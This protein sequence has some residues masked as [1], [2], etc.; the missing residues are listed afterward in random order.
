[1][2]PFWSAR[3]V[4]AIVSLLTAMSLP[5]L[6]ATASASPVNV[7]TRSGCTTYWMFNGVWRVRVTEA[8]AYID[9]ITH[10]QTGWQ[11]SEQWRNG[12]TQTITPG[13]SVTLSQQLVLQNGQTVAA[14][15]TT[16]GTLSQQQID[17]HQFPPSAQFSHAQVFL[18]PSLDANNKPV[19]VIIAFDAAKLRQFGSRPQFSV[20]PPN[21]RINFSCSPTEAARA[22]AAQGGSVEVAAHEGCLNQWLSNGLWRVRISNLA[23]STNYNQQVGWQLTEDWVNLSGKKI[24][25]VNTAILDQQLALKSEDTVSSGRSVLTGLTAQKLDYHDFAPGTSFTH[26]QPFW[27]DPPFDATNTPTKLLIMFDA[28]ALARNPDAPRFTGPANIRIN[29]GCTK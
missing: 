12:T 25:P 29:L 8:T 7:A 24:E 1:M 26:T 21:Y 10:T 2:S 16:T 11:V 15:D 22:A 6:P 18:V 20:S 17:Y 5:I 4:T 23:P 14:Q 27:P 13:D 9:S 19:A 28:K 3:K